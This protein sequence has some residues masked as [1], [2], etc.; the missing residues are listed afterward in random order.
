MLL[1]IL[2]FNDNQNSNAHT[3]AAPGRRVRKSLS[4][5]GRSE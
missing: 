3:K 5:Q 1:M 2:S 4:F